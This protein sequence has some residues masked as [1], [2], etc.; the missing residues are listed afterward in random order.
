M[1]ILAF[2]EIAAEYETPCIYHPSATAISPASLWNGWP[3]FK[4]SGSRGAI[5]LL[6]LAA[7]IVT[8]LLWSTAAQAGIL[9]PGQVLQQ[10][11]QSPLVQQLQRR[12][13]ETGFFNAEATG[14][15]GSI[16]TEAVS[17]YQQSVGLPS[18][19]V[20]G[21]TTDRRLFDFSTPQNTNSGASGGSSSFRLGDR[22]LSRGDQ[23][24]DVRELQQLLNERVAFTAIDGDFGS[25]TE[26]RVRQFQQFKG[27]LVDGV[28]GASTITALRNQAPGQ[29]SVPPSSETPNTP[30]APS[31]SEAQQASAN[32]AQINRG[33]YIVV[34]P[35]DSENRTQLTFV[36]RTQPSACMARSRQ[37][38]Y[39]FAGGY[40]TFSSAES[41]Q[42]L[43]R[44][45]RQSADVSR[46]DAR[47]DYRRD[48]NFTVECLY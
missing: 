27:L 35:T 10:G 22:P 38:S 45:K 14:F 11:S 9:A 6:V 29:I 19:G 46:L 43:L 2:L 17:R 15:Y 31:G 4:R 23:G 36:R 16:T 47:V 42:L 39:I 3:K 5:A 28:A 40:P 30:P 33:N 12:L 13:R 21:P 41:M 32:A 48:D 8:H 25:I 1:E 26:T 18:D 7:N 37:G 20:Y 24:A 34:I 44:S